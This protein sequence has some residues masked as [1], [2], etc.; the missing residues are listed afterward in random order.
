MRRLVFLAAALVASLA[1][2]A[3]ASAQDHSTRDSTR[4]D[5]EARADNRR[6]PVTG[7]FSLSVHTHSRQFGSPSGVQT[8]F[9]TN[10]LEYPVRSGGF[11][12]SSIPCSSP[13]PFNDRAL[14][15]TPGYPDLGSGPLAVR[16]RVKGVVVTTNGSDAGTVR[17]T[18]TTILC[19]NGQETKDRIRFR[20]EGQFV[21][22]SQNE[23]MVNG[24][25]RVLGGTGRF[26]GLHGDGSV[27]GR[28]T[29]LPPALQRAGARNCAEL[30]AFSDAVFNLQG[31]YA[32]RHPRVA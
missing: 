4:Q 2:T 17:G 15:F 13:A 26:A 14:A 3:P 12:Y 11:S 29:C 5:N 27:T 7:Q 28:F 25:F 1:V 16:H 6:D 18:I 20:F 9:P 22:T 19:Q 23:A 8:L 21:V 32:N 10:P 24:T 31:S 30:G